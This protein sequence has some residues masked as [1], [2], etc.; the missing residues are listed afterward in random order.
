MVEQKLMQI[1][2]P[3]EFEITESI[4]FDKKNYA[5]KL[6]DRILQFKFVSMTA[7]SVKL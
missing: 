7:F 5:S 4:V 3:G 1:W 6:R 2:H